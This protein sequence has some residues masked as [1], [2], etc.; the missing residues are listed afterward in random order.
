PIVSTSKSSNNAVL[1]DFHQRLAAYQSTIHT[2]YELFPTQ[3]NHSTM[4]DNSNNNTIAAVSPNSNSNSY[5]NSH[6]YYESSN[7]STS[8]QSVSIAS[9][10]DQEYTNLNQENKSGAPAGNVINAD[11]L[12]D[13]DKLG[14]TCGT[15]I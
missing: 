12:F 5:S 7:N 10:V 3:D 4:Q 8:D 13:I 14:K 9:D 2:G 11:D 6:S 15:I 1:S